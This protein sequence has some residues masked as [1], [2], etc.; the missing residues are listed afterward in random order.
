[1]LLDSHFKYFVF[2]RYK[3][4]QIVLNNFKRERF[5]QTK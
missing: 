1:M 2:E 5:D 3:T 4:N